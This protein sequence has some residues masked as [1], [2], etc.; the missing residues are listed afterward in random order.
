MLGGGNL[1]C[2]EFWSPIVEKVSKKLVKWKKFQ[3]SCGGGLALCNSV[4]SNIP[5]CDLK[6]FQFPSNVCSQLEKA[7]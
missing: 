6:F 1:I 3:L 4:P 2:S 5:I 7:E